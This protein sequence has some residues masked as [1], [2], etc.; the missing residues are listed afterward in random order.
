MY[1]YY[2]NN[3][4]FIGDSMRILNIVLFFV[5]SSFC[6]AQINIEYLNDV[7]EEFKEKYFSQ[8]RDYNPLQVGN[9]W[10]YY[11]AEYNVHST[12]KVLQD[13]IINGKKYFK[14]SIFPEFTTRPDANISWERNDTTS[15]VSFM[16]DFEDVNNNGDFF[17]ELPLDSLENPYWSRYKT[18]KYPFFGGIE[19]TTLVKDTSWVI[20]EGDTVISRTFEIIDLFWIEEIIEKFGIFWNW[21]ESPARYCTG[22]II[23]GR[24]YGTIVSVY[25]NSE[26]THTDFFLKNNYPNPF[27]PSTTINYQLPEQS[28]VSI[29]VYNMLGETISVLKN[30]FQNSGSYS[31]E[32]DGSDLPSG[33]YLYKIQA[34]SYYEVK[35]MLLVK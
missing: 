23:N 34:G 17:E 9:I 14:K 33:T 20:L 11:D 31:L 32:F 26:R 16:L 22:A 10:Q 1:F 30:E 19:K 2:G 29:K 7:P 24:Q 3:F 8:K 27:N 13:S 25:D 12:I 4:I 21:S 18:Y 15:G 5:L 6:F 28:F 35:K